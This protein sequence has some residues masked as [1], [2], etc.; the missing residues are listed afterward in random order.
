MEMRSSINEARL[1]QRSN[2]IR[3]TAADLPVQIILGILKASEYWD[4]TVKT[5]EFVLRDWTEATVLHGTGKR[6]VQRSAIWDGEDEK[7]WIL[8]WWQHIPWVHCGGS[9]QWRYQCIPVV[10]CPCQ[11]SMLQTEDCKDTQMEIINWMH[12]LNKSLCVEAE[13]TWW[14]WIERVPLECLVNVIQSIIK[15]NRMH[16]EYNEQE[17]ER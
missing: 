2:S 9:W 7:W 1:R 8:A 17:N 10:F 14:G 12:A 13:S 6:R 3:E 4:R 16:A 15:M 11:F 5:L